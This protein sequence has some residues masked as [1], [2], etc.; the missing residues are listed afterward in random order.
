MVA[1]AA[2]DRS[3]RAID[4]GDTFYV[5]RKGRQT[6]VRLKDFGSIDIDHLGGDGVV[7]APM[8]GKV[9]AVLVEQ[10]ERVARGHRLAV[11]EAM[12][13]EHALLA[14]VDGIVSEIAIAAGAQV[15]EGAKILTISAIAE[16]EED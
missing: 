4:G 8:H 15:A 9:L 5:L 13:M 2:P 14:P 11:I 12:K 1:G 16:E 7:A 6:A 10:G 3:T